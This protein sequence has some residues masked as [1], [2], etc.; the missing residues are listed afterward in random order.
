MMQTEISNGRKSQ[1]SEE[2][3]RF[4]ELKWQQ[5]AESAPDYII[6]I[7]RDGKIL[8]L[9]RPITTQSIDDVIGRDATDFVGPEQAPIMLKALKKVF[10]TAQ[11]TEYEILSKNSKSEP[12][13]YSTR[14]APFIVDGKVISATL[15]T[16]DISERKKMEEELKRVK[17]N[18]ELIVKERTSKIEETLSKFKATLE[19]T[20]DGIL[21]IDLNRRALTYNQ[22]LLQMWNVKPEDMV[23]YRS[24]T[25]ITAIKDQLKDTDDFLKKTENIY[26]HPYDKSADVL[27]FKDGR[28]F[29]RYSQPQWLNSEVV[30]RVWSFRDVTEQRNAE[31]ERDRLL[32]NE[33]QARIDAEKSVKM[34]DD[35]LAMASHELRTPLT[36]L[37]M[38]LDW[39][40]REVRKIT[41][42]VLPK[43]D[44]LKQALDHT[45]RE[46]TKLIHLTDDLLDVSRITA[47]RLVLNKEPM[48]LVELV[49]K[50]Q[51]L[52]LENS[53]RRDCTI[54]LETDGPVNGIWDYNR[55]EQVFNC[56]LSNATKYGTGK[57]VY[58]SVKKENNR[59]VLRIEDKG[60]GIAPEDQEKIFQ[61]F[62]RATSIK[63]FDGL[64]LGLFISREVV[65]AHGGTISVKSEIEK[66]STFTVSLPIEL[67]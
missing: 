43:A 41:P 37:K 50:A 27:E 7:G 48:D 10:T 15:I 28:L 54:S 33:H 26:A 58:I 62:E 30:G 14:V 17:E 21:V 52:N 40:K 24:G 19:S 67:S 25:L 32:K 34:R 35:F 66:G 3:L 55:I 64:G 20:A 36:P 42:E 47:G 16:R 13:W 8:F 57:P 6:S 46:A 22:K 44:V 38:Y 11:S 51:Q 65:L 59:A 1:S 31:A 23:N 2:A 39:F 56:L 49:L 4:S 45:D 9:N 18:L 53:N 63:N 29:E 5:L 61:R 12:A 60:I